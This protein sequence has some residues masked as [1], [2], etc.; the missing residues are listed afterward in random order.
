MKRSLDPAVLTN[1]QFIAKMLRRG[2]PCARVYGIVR[3][4]QKVCLYTQI[5][6]TFHRNIVCRNLL[7]AI[8]C[9]FARSWN[10]NKNWS[11]SLPPSHR[12]L[13]RSL[14]EMY[15]LDGSTNRQL[16]STARVIPILGVD[17]TFRVE[18]C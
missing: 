13:I 14:L 6:T 3:G 10:K 16:L 4:H 8:H 2:L 1:H 9:G 18:P 12:I 11:T 7:I 15:L 17:D 5:G